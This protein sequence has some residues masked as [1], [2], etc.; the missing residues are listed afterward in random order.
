MLFILAARTTSWAARTP[1]FTPEGAPFRTSWQ[2]AVTTLKARL[3]SLV[4]RAHYAAETITPNNNVSLVPAVLGH[5]L[6]Q[7]PAL[8]LL[9]KR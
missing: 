5:F 2:V 3:L 6:G 1:Q 9:T 8:L 7:F 4:D